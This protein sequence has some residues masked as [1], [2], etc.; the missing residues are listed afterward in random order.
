GTIVALVPEGMMPTVTL[1]LAAGSQRMAKRNALVK[2]LNA[3]ETLGC[4]TVICTDKTGTITENNMRVEKVWL[5]NDS[6]EIRE[7]AYMV[8]GLAN[9]IPFSLSEDDRTGD[10][11][12]LALVR[13]A[14]E[15]YRDKAGVIPRITR[16][17]EFGFTPERK[18]MTVVYGLDEGGGRLAVTKGAMEVM[19]TLCR[20]TGEQIERIEKAAAEIAGQAM[21]VMALAVKTGEEGGADAAAWEE[22]MTFLG[23]VG[24]DDPIRADVPEAVELCHN[25]GIRVMMITGDMPATAHA[26]ARR[27][28]I[29]PDESEPVLL[30][31][32][33]IEEMSPE[34]IKEAL[35]A[36]HIVFARMKPEHKL[37]IV[38]ALQE[39]GEVVAMT[40]DGVNDA[41][42]LR[43]SDIGIAMGMRGNDVARETA[44]IV[45]LDDHFATIVSAVE[46][47][48]AVFSNIR[49]FITYVLAS[50]TAE[51]VPYLCFV[52]LRIPL[53]LP[54][55]QV[56]AIDL[57]T[58]LFPALALGLEKPGKEAMKR[59]PRSREE[60]LMNTGLL[61][62]AFVFLGMIEAIAGM[63]G[64]FYVMYGGGW[65]WGG[66][67]GHGDPLYLQATTACL[68]GIVMAQ[69][70][71]LFTCRSDTISAFQPSLKRNPY[72]FWGLAYEVGVLLFI[73]YTLPGNTLFRTLPISTDVWLFMLILPP[74]LLLADEIRK[75]FARRRLKGPKTA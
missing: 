10:P 1:T 75:F 61:L 43:K 62:R 29:V 53:P 44:D 54:I 31:G 13:A 7:K 45:L 55:I 26:I 39:M 52:L 63:A 36:S 65:Q 34:N 4:T 5:L 6:E 57:G 73:V 66:Q 18:R 30:T 11:M 72:I 58:D 46:E 59:P 49:K 56:I 48:R 68:A 22:D 71:N 70:A 9:S 60:R 27:A 51:I 3:I 74:V 64:Y 69:M 37:T 16:M 19:P 2:K 50:N 21:R 38:S 25:A 35:R 28:N 24:L 33:A 41:P 14:A 40:G 42:A 47:G 20:L 8:M 17:E 15:Y 32:S 67:L 12:E 23:L